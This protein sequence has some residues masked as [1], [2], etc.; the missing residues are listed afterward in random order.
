[1]TTSVGPCGPHW[2]KGNW[3][4]ALT[5][6]A[7]YTCANGKRKHGRRHQRVRDSVAHWAKWP[8]GPRRRDGL[9]GGLGEKNEE[10]RPN[11]SAGPAYEF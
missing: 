8:F 7:G 5:C 11:R 1:V 10:A 3:A 2:P 6:S 4:G 9:A